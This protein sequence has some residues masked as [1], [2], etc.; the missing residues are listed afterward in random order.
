MGTAPPP[1]IYIDPTMV[2]TA[3]YPQLKAEYDN[4]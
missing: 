4:L 1:E 3:L 2:T